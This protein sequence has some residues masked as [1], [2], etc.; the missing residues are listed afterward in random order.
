[1]R[2]NFMKDNASKAQGASC[3]TAIQKKF[4]GNLTYYRAQKRGL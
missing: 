1:M 4:T 3:C 2:P